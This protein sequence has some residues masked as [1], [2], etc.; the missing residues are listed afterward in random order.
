AQALG[1]TAPAAGGAAA[2]PPLPGQ[3][4][5]FFVA[6]NNQQA[7]PFDLGALRQHARSGSLTRETLVW[8][9]GMASWTPAGQ[10]AELASLFAPVP[11]PLPPKA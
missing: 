5:A 6:I 2:P 10:V 4:A 9:Q 7:G 8:K 11:P 1:G 3:A